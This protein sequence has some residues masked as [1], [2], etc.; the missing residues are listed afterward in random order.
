MPIVSHPIDGLEGH[1][2]ATANCIDVGDPRDYK[3][4]NTV[5]LAKSA[6]T[7]MLGSL[8]LIVVWEQLNIARSFKTDRIWI[9]NVGDLK[10][11]ETPLELFMSLAYDFDAVP[12]DG[13]KVYL[14]GKARRDYGEDVDA[15]EVADIIATY[16]V[17]LHTVIGAALTCRS[18]PLAAKPSSWTA[19]PTRSPPLTSEL[20]LQVWEDD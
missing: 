20:S 10:V 3:W 1:V 16:S 5:P 11:L 9:C 6:F 17:S 15:E 2:W 13:L 12:R 7:H 19:I 4:T 18:M 8:I 14:A